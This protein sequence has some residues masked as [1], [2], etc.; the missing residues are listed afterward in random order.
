MKQE[1]PGEFFGGDPE[2]MKNAIASAHKL[3]GTHIVRFEVLD[4][5]SSRLG[6]CKSVIIGPSCTI[7]DLDDAMKQ[8]LD[9]ELA[10]TTKFPV[11]YMEVPSE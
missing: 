1:T 2:N 9:M 8:K 11:A 3:G 10:S 7:K 6:E 5:C 4:M